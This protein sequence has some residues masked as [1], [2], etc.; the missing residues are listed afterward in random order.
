MS[1]H[2]VTPE[3]T[4]D[5]QLERAVARMRDAGT[6]ITQYELKEARGYPAS[7]VESLCAFANTRG[8]VIILGVSEADFQ[9]VDI[10]VR[11]LQVRLAASARTEIE[12]AIQVDIRVLY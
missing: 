3:I 7:V 4:T 8:G 11:N 6:D 5:E 12:P 9:P 2:Y 1:N 10:D